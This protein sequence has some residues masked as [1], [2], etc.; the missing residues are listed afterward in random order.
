MSFELPDK[1]LTERTVEEALK[2]DIGI[3][4]DITSNLILDDSNRS[5]FEIKSR[6]K[7]VISGLYLAETAFR[8]IDKNITFEKFKEEGDEVEVDNILVRI[9]GNS[10]SILTAERTALNFLSHMSGI[11]S[12]TSLMAKKI[13]NTNT[14]I[15]CTRKTTP[16][17]R[18]FEK[19]AVLSG[20]GKN[21][22]F[23]L[24]DGILI[25][26][27]HIALS[28]SIKE[29]IKK[30]KNSS[31][32]SIKVEVEVDNIDQFQE[33]LENNPDIILLDNFSTSELKKAVEINNDK[34]LLEA[35]GSVNIENVLDIA[36]TGVDFI[37]S[38]WLTH[39][40]PSL[41]FGLDLKQ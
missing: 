3:T 28:G 18:I 39:S 34:V 38:G 41:D 4:G 6:Q 37:S 5:E 17:L 26:D 9:R 10:I 2:E 7:G 30:A 22:R 12:A 1:T 20:G 40:S 35:S 32:K 24:F 33:A 25:K 21:H 36:M 29:A 23:G 19:F 16:N 11:A 31:D 27:N 14:K 13:K 15:M 8:L